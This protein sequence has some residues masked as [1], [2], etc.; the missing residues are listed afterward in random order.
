[1]NISK[2]F[3]GLIVS[4]LMVLPACLSSAR[5]YIYAKSL[6][7]NSIQATD[8]FISNDFGLT[9]RGFFGGA[10]RLFSDQFRSFA[11]NLFAFSISLIA[12]FIVSLVLAK[13]SRGVSAT[14]RLALAY[15]PAFFPAFC[16]WDLQGQGRKE[17]L[18]FVFVVI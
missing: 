1:M 11:I 7:A 4:F 14:A 15:S 3:S 17:A 6:D 18:A 10:L 16:L 8:W 5:G 12:A 9:R 2:K 13:Y